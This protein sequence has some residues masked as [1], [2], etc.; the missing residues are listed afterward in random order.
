M[1]L[2]SSFSFLQDRL[3]I[4]TALFDISRDN[5]AALTTI[6][7]VETVVFDSQSTRGGEL[8]L[9]T[10]ITDQW[11][12]LANFTLQRAVITDN[13]QGISSIG[14]HPQGAPASIANLWTTYDFS[15]A[16]RPGFRVGA[17]A[18]YQSTTY[19]DITNVNSI[20]AYVIVNALVGY[21]APQWG[22][23]LNLHNITNQR[24]FVAANVAGALVGEPFS[25]L[26]NLHAHF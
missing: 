17:G 2:T 26:V 6:G 24:Y 15:I 3:V 9:D 21:E 23:D 8:S 7:G 5:V 11:H 4:N 12:L 25:A 10:R 19:S 16:G 13:P 22:N 14:K 1:K 20:P 18:N